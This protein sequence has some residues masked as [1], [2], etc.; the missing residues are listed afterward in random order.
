MSTPIHFVKP[1]A[2]GLLSPLMPWLNHPQVSEILINKPK[3]VFI[4][5]H[6]VMTRH[7][8][9]ELTS[10]YLHRLFQMIA[11]ESQ[12][13][14][15][16]A[17]PLLSGNLYN[18]FR[19]QL[20]IP[21]V[22][23]YHSLAIRKTA[24]SH[25]LLDDY[26]A[27]GF[28]RRMQPMNLNQAMSHT[29]QDQSLLHLYQKRCWGDFIKT[30]VALRKNIVISGGTSSG[31]TTFLKAC[32]EAIPADERIIV[33]EDTR[34]L[35]SSHANQVSLLASHGN[36]GKAQVTM[37]TLVQATLRLR[38][39]RLIM[40]EIRGKEIM[41]FVMACSTGHEGSITSIHAN[42]P[43]IAMQRMVQLYKQNNVPSMRD[44]EIRAELNQ[45]IDI[46]IQ[47]GK[48]GNERVALSCYYKEAQ[49]NHALSEVAA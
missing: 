3:E 16:E 28:Y 37:Q 11:N 45:V 42:N 36:Q 4:E 20:I 35:S 8:I 18:G 14:L 12:Q 39:D 17:H 9:P 44:E 22:S 47:L 31:K 10:L 33:L 23:L 21:P 13:R 27:Q 41:D 25:W 6:G 40:G 19:V 2:E 30:A 46:I 48:V 29:A 26:S 1:G 34:E 7:E 38:P 5:L 15:D 49:V 32:L 24:L 43:Q